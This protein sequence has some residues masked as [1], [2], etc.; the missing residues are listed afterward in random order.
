MELTKNQRKR[1]SLIGGVSG[2]ITGF[3]MI[4]LFKNNLGFIPAILGAL[5]LV[6]RRNNG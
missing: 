1:W 5:L 4:F 2:L 3:G 6:V